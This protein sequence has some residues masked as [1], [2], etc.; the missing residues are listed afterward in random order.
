M[1][2]SIIVIIALAA[3]VSLSAM[4]FAAPKAGRGP[5][6]QEQSAITPEQRAA[7]QKIIEA[8]QDKLYELREKIWAKH[9]ELQALTNSGKAEK[10]DIQALIA[11]ISKLRSAMNQERLSI[12]TDIEKQTGL[13]GYGGYHRGGMGYGGGH[14]GGYG[15]CADDSG[16][17][18]GYGG[19]GAGRGMNGCTGGSC[20]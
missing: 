13:K 15:A 1:K 12:R 7:I 4:A 3:L 11:D 16:C 10:N 17:P 9:A 5:A 8:H 18:S 19:K 20:N 6:Q 2:K 14:G